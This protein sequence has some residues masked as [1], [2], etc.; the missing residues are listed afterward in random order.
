MEEGVEQ[1]VVQRL[2]LRLRLELACRDELDREG[3]LWIR[4]C[5]ETLL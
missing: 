5:A 4:L 1:V 2:R 3:E